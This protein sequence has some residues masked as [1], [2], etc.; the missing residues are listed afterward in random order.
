MSIGFDRAGEWMRYSGVKNPGL[1]AIQHFN[2]PTE[3]M[4]LILGHPRC[5]STFAAEAASSVG[6]QIGHETLHEHG[7]SSWM[8]A[9]EDMRA[10][11][12][13]EYG[14]WP[15]STSFKV[16]IHHLRDPFDAI[17]SIMSENRIELSMRYRTRHI[18]DIFGF[19]IAQLETQI[20]RAVA[21][22]LFWNKIIEMRRPK[23]W[24]R[25]EDDV[26]KLF[27]FLAVTFPDQVDL[28]RPRQPLKRANLHNDHFTKFGVVNKAVLEA[29]D[30]SKLNATLAASLRQ[31]CE[32]YGYEY[33]L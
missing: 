9:V 16:I 6:L 7:M 26:E 4:L 20:D 15:M 3:R 14:L 27:E 17:P 23:F 1:A 8:F 5:G 11:F 21:S 22:Y 24:F 25:I 33:R 2:P 10:P 18:E 19:D 12:G 31:F 30:W 32:V 29:K 28:T 13:R